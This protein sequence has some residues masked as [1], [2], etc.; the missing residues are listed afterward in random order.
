MQLT[1]S[2][3]ANLAKHDLSICCRVSIE[4]GK[5]SQCEENISGKIQNVSAT[6]YTQTNE[7]ISLWSLAWH[8]SFTCEYA[9]LYWN[10]IQRLLN[11]AQNYQQNV[12]NWWLDRN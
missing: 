8:H 6:F 5:S 10:K 11:I 12:S 7:D 4:Q 9:N 2:T 1:E 3:D